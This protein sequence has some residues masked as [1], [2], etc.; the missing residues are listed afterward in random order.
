MKMPGQN[1]IF[2]IQWKDLSEARIIVERMKYPVP[3]A[4]QWQKEMRAICSSWVPEN[5]KRT[6]PLVSCPESIRK[7]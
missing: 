7:Q 4:R 3:A 2:D 1:Q 6:C 5:S